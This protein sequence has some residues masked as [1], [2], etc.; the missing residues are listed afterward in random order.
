MMKRSYHTIVIGSGCAGFAAAE[1]LW[2]LGVTDIALLTEGRNMGT[3]RNTGSDKQTYYKLS[4][5]GSEGD[6]VREMAQTL[7]DGGGVNGDNAMCEAAYSVRC[8]MHLVEL[9]VPFPCN[10]YGEYAGYKTDHDPRTR[11]TSCGPLTSKYMTE[12]L[13]RAVNGYGIPILDGWRAVRV[14]T[15]GGRVTGVAAIRQGG[16]RAVFACRNLILATGGPAAIY[17]NSVY[18]ESQTGATGLAIG[19]GA[20]CANLEEW[21]YGIASTDFRW[22]LSGTYQQVLPRYFSVGADGVERE[23]LWEA[24]GARSLDLIFLKG[25]QWPFDTRKLNGSSQVDLLVADEIRNGRRV[26]LDFTRNPIGL[27][28]AFSALGEEG[29]D[30]LR[31]SGALFGTPLERLKHM[32]IGA[33]ELYRNHGIDLARAPLRIAVC[34]QH[35]NGGIAVDAY[36][37]T[38]VAGLYAV[39]EAAGNF[40]VYRPGGSALNATQVG[41]LR[42]AEQ[43]AAQSDRTAPETVPSFAFPEYRR[44]ESNIRALYGRLRHE[45]SR[46]ADFA[47]NTAEMKKMLAEVSD[48]CYNTEERLIVGGAEDDLPAVLLTDLLLTQQ[49]VLSAMLFSAETVGSHGSAYI[50]GT[51]VPSEQPIRRTYTV[52]VGTRSELCPVRPIPDGELWFENLLRRSLKA[53]RA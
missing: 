41:A 36:W 53:D 33:Y 50:V 16:E 42:A 4:L 26:Y 9:G 28:E 51:D 40:G 14:L 15:D 1:R 44:G 47:R 37:Q 22:N 6:S 45:M 11:A 7:F 52:T 19:A 27:D 8:F 18:P 17:E 25:Y 20:A 39:G 46:V 3:S 13:E 10:E 38:S 34:A 12:A 48:L 30:Y 21:Q 2:S 49:A 5:C 43:I 23:F 31:R 24:L 32:N 35:C 29:R